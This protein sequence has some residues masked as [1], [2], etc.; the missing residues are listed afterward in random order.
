MTEKFKF[1]KYCGNKIA[2]ADVKSKPKKLYC[3]RECYRKQKRIRDRN[4]KTYERNVSKVRA[5]WKKRNPNADIHPA[6]P[7]RFND[8]LKCDYC[9][10]SWGENQIYP[11]PL[12]SNPQAHGKIE[13]NRDGKPKIIR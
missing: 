2:E 10:I 1:C 6:W 5:F 3:S 11:Q 9:G 4:R 7:H 8:T 12:C 13:L